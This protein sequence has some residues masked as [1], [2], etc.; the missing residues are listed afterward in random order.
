MV[1][2]ARC[3][4]AAVAC[5]A[6]LEGVQELGGIGGVAAEVVHE[7]EGDGVVLGADGVDVR[8]EVRLDAA[9]ALSVRSQ[10]R[11]PGRAASPLTLRMRF[12]LLGKAWVAQA[13]PRA[14]NAAW[15]PPPQDVAVASSRAPACG[16]APF[17]AS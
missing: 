13:T 10:G 3:A 17:Y 12:S 7:V 15:D 1:H 5:G 2:T 16:K 4:V 11:S 6:L 8:A 9:D 14:L